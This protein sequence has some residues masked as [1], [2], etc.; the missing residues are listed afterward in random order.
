MLLTQICRFCPREGIIIMDQAFTYILLFLI[1]VLLGHLFQKS[2]IPLAL[3]LVI[4]GML[5]SFF[6]FLKETTLNPNLVLNFFLPLLIYQISAFSSWRAI[7][8]LI[9]PVASLSIGHVIFITCLVA[10]LFHD[11]TP[12]IGWPL[13]FVLGAI[14]APPDSV[15]IVAI[16]EKIRIPERIFNVLKG[17]GVFN[18]AAA[19][20]IFRFALAAAVTH[21]FS[22]LNTIFA[23]VVVILGEIAYGLILGH[24]LG[25]VRRRIVSNNLHLIASFITPFLAY[26]PPSLLGGTG[27][28]ATAVVGFLIGNQ[29]AFH[30]RSEF[31]LLSMGMWPAISSAIEAIIFLLVGL[32]MHSIFMRIS[33][34]PAE[35]LLL[36]IVTVVCAVILGRFIWVYC[37]V[38]SFPRLLFPDLR[39]KKYPPW[40]N[41]FL[42]SWA[43]MRGGIS[44]AAAFA[45]PALI[46]KVN[47]IDLR[48]L[49]IFLVFVLILVTLVLQGL[50][51]P[52]LLRKMG[53]EKIG[54]T[55]R[56]KEHM[57]ELK[58]RVQMIR[59]ALSWLNEYKD[60]NKEKTDLCDEVNFRVT[61][62]QMLEKKYTNRITQHKKKP[63][64]D[65]KLEIKESMSLLLQVVK[66]EKTELL[67]LWREQEISLATRNKLLSLLDHQI[68]RFK[69]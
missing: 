18:D 20:T 53:F 10:I 14:V 43:G 39:K 2:T 19:L 23:F 50:S 66:V 58:A 47:G 46:F 1:I 59:A 55:E 37:T 31:R 12:Q 52:F 56:Y 69:I 35:Q 15:A 38:A 41:F 27:V 24:L 11:L 60:K 61:E 22:I 5:L 44:L 48:D 8:R 3:I 68:Q 65:E 29:Y 63:Y 26:I 33:I 36:Y 32:N 28:I 21:K 64:H 17:E 6:P 13:A 67:R 45:M 42:V 4:F 9:R 54:Q 62:Y 7:R 34:L 16:Y 40:R 57:S 49:I 25:K 51:L 30:F